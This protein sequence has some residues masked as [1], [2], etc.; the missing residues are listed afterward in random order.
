MAIMRDRTLK[1]GL[2]GLA[3]G[4]LASFQARG[5]PPFVTDDP[6]PVEYR[7]YE[8]NIAYEEVSNQGGKTA[9]PLVELNYGALPDLQMSITI[10]YVLDYPTGQPKQKGLGDVVLGVKY[11]FQQET[12]EQPMMAVYPMVTV[13]TG[14]SAKGLGNGKAQFFLPLWIQKR[15]GDWQASGGGGYWINNSPGTGN[16]WY[17]GLLVQ[18]DISEKITVGAEMFHTTDQIPIDNSSTGFSIGGTY[19]LDQNNRLMA[20][21]GRGL[22]DVAA[23]NTFSSYI[24]YGLSW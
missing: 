15:W 24:G 13:P 5:A 9:T 17:F 22:A 18:K 1:I 7:H 8:L 11:R 21:V 10:P 6:E 23:Q 20:S 2:L 12:D 14:N 16:N 3:T 4:C 19:K